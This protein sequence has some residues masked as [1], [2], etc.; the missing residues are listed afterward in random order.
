MFFRNC[1]GHT[2]CNLTLRWAGKVSV[3]AAMKGFNSTAATVITD[4]T[5]PC[6]PNDTPIC[7]ATTITKGGA[8]AM[9]AKIGG[10]GNNE[11]KMKKVNKI[12]R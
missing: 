3:N 11:M 9:T 8:E 2:D 1:N 6:T 10:K 7:R 4:D 5:T 12:T